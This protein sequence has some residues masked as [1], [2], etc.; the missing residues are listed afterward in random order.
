MIRIPAFF[1]SLG[2]LFVTLFGQLAAVLA[3]PEEGL[4]A[5]VYGGCDPWYCQ[6]DGVYYHC[7]STGNGVG[8]KRADSIEGLSSAPGVT[9]YTAPEG[10]DY[11]RD[12]WAPELYRIDGRWYIY[13]AAD[14]GENANHRMYVLGCDEPQGRYTMEGKLND[15]SDKWAIDGT[16]LR[17]GG[18]LYFVWSGWENDEDGRQNLYIAPM[19]SPTHI[20]GERVRISEPVFKWEKNGMPVNEGPAALYKDNETYI[21]YSASGSWTDDYCLGMLRLVG[22]D[23]LREGCWAK[24]P[25][26]VFQKTDTLF[27][28]GHCSFVSSPDGETDYIV[29]HANAESG[30]GWNGRSVR[31]QAFTWRHNTPVFGKP[32]DEA[33]PSA[34]TA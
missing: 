27:G 16:L 14:D 23:P 19:D 31:V 1:V 17:H 29:Y 4:A 11:S 26:A 6:Y 10:T 21:V 22:N 3:P 13:V 2:M 34:P 5:P 33:A 28:P 24:C 7:Y 25:V 9:V 30:T 12:Y 20:S 18:N 15:P 8:V 32:I